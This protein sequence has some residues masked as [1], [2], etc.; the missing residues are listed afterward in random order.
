MAVRRPIV[1]G[2]FYEGNTERLKAQ[3]E[4]CFLHKKGPGA[5]PVDKREKRIKAVVAPHAGYYFSG[6]CAAWGYKEVAEA[7]LPDC[8]IVI[9]PNHSGI[10]KSSLIL[11]EWQTPFGVV[12]PDAELGRALIAKT[13]LV[14]DRSAHSNEHSIEVQLPFLQFVN[15]GVLQKMR[16]LPICLRDDVNIHKL[17][18]DIKEAIVDSGREVVY[19]VSS[20]MTHYGAQYG[21]LPFSSDIPKR[22]YELD[23]GM[24]QRIKS[25]NPQGILDYTRETGATVCGVLPLVLLTLLLK[26][27]GKLLQYYTSA[28][29]RGDYRNAVGYASIVFD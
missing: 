14:E 2:S 25:L 24:I 10:G 6:P 8:Y 15:N 3:I 16:F 21:Y 22:L 4:E 28:D 7:E 23:A 29:I 17:A 19:V 12:K 9:G 11:D 26:T 5:L 18:L 1:A 20:D 13:E 27:E